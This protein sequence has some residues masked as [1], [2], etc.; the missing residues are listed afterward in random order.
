[1]EG[2]SGE[3]VVW[4][5]MRDTGKGIES[6]FV[7]AGIV[8]VGSG[9]RSYECFTRIYLFHWNQVMFVRDFFLLHFSSV[10]SS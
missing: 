5:K 4:G 1:M 10:F 2:D 7:I 6:R 9:V 8:Y 3:Q